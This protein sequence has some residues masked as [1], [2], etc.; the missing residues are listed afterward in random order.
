MSGPATVVVETDHHLALAPLAS[1]VCIEMPA[2]LPALGSRIVLRGLDGAMRDAIVTTVD[3]RSG[4][5]AAAVG[6]PVTRRQLI[7][8]GYAWSGLRHDGGLRFVVCG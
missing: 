5:I 8:R 6:W 1:L 3:P 2:G 4:A 7:E